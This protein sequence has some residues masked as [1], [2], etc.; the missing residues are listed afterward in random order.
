M[1][2]LLNRVWAGLVSIW[3]DARWLLSVLVFGPVAV[4]V[5]AGLLGLPVWLAFET[6]LAVLVLWAVSHFLGA[7]GASKT[8]KSLT[9]FILAVPLLLPFILA[10]GS[11]IPGLAWLTTTMEIRTEPWQA[12]NNVESRK[13]AAI[14]ENTQF[15]NWATAQR[16]T[17]FYNANGQAVF[18]LAQGTEVMVMLEREVA[19]DSPLHVTKSRQRYIYVALPDSNN[20]PSNV[21]GYVPATDLSDPRPKGILGRDEKGGQLPIREDYIKELNPGDPPIFI[22]LPRYHLVRVEVLGDTAVKY[23]Q[24]G[25]TLP[26][27]KN[28]RVTLDHRFGVWYEPGKL[29]NRLRI[30]TQRNPK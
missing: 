8:V 22:D 28:D 15:G 29:P 23:H 3:N 2:T 26:I 1:Q 14:A 5:L 24:W 7:T 9:V 20:H 4:L 10:V 13:L 27:S 12:R 6:Y 25:K 11:M 16:H 21:A 18:S 30:I 17:R 19:A